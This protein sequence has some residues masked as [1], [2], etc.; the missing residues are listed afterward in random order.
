MSGFA[1]GMLPPLESGSSFSGTAATIQQGFAMQPQNLEMPA[2]LREFDNLYP[3]LEGY[4]GN[5]GNLSDV[6]G[7]LQDTNNNN[8]NKEGDKNMEE[9]GGGGQGNLLDVLRRR[10]KAANSKL[11]TLQWELKNF[12]APLSD[13][14]HS[15]FGKQLKE[16]Q[17]EFETMENELEE[18]LDQVLMVP[19]QLHLWKQLCNFCSLKVA[20]I[21]VFKDE[22]KAVWT[23]KYPADGFGAIIVKSQPFPDVVKQKEKKRTKGHTNYEE[24]PIEVQ[25]LNGARSTIVIAGKVKAELQWETAK[26]QESKGSSSILNPTA[27]VK[28]T[29][30]ANFEELRFSKGTGVKIVRLVFTCRAKAPSTLEIPGAGSE[31]EL[32]SNPTEPFIVMTNESQFSD[33]AKKLLDLAVFGE[34][35]DPVPWLRFA[36]HLQL[37]YLTS[38]RQNLS[39]IVRPLTKADLA[40]IWQLKFKQ[41][42][43]V[44]PALF[45][46]FWGWF[47]KLVHVLRHQKPV[48]ELWEKGL[49]FGFISKDAAGDILAGRDVGTFLIRFSEQSAGQFAVACVAKGKE[50][51]SKVIKHMLVPQSTK[52]LSDWVRN[53]DSLKTVVLC[54]TAFRV[55]N[56]R[57]MVNGTMHKDGAFGDFYTDKPGGETAI[58]GY[59]DLGDDSE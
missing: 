28:K 34:S 26:D 59:D 5:G 46:D 54:K 20:A 19:A 52:K 7:N 37:H 21:D 11:E 27:S 45:N 51:G 48:P 22:L 53:K 30:I 44:S 32:E 57:G 35:D 6:L 58:Q 14:Q 9:E 50:A 4:G 56:Y 24:D 16:L 10:Y 39:K 25:V 40:Y 15:S 36:N 18:L 29:G 8:D 2:M 3:T 47:G 23:N 49:I 38:T 31:F 1:F 12:I 13:E 17:A 43:Q 33:S 41:A 42:K 55:D